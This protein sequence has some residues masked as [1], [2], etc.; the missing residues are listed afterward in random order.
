MPDR[1]P[2]AT[3]PAETAYCHTCGFEHT[4]RPDWLCPR[5]GMP[6]STEP[7]PRRTAAASAEKPTFPMGSTIAGA[8]M[9]VNAVALLIGFGRHPASEYRWAVLGT[10][11][12]LGVL[13]LELL[14]MVPAG[15]WIALVGAVGAA[16][17]VSEDV[18]RERVP[19]LFRDP[20][21]DPIRHFLRDVFHDLRPTGISFVLGFAV[22]CLLLV[23]GRPRRMRIAAGVALAVPLAVLEMILVFGP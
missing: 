13:A 14:L 10:A 8:V 4:R 1:S 22:G 19:D 12:V 17:I 18:V 11:S 5:C 6:A 2:H 15:R 9:A 3:L 20:L 16:L 23:V 7:P 21:P